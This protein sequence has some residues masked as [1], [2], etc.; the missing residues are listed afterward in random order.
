[1]DALKLA[2]WQ[3]GELERLEELTGELAR[4]L[5]AQPEDEFYLQFVLLESAFAPLGAGRF[6]EAIAR[7]EEALAL[8]RQRGRLIHEP[9]FIDALCW[10]YRSRGDYE[11]ALASGS[12]ASELAHQIGHH[13]WAAW[14]DATLGWA[15]LDARVPAA[16]V[17][18]L[19]RGMQTA[20][21]ASAPAQLVR[22]VALLAWARSMLGE[23]ALA[24]ALATR[25][26]ELLSE[27]TT[28]P[29]GA[30]LFGAHAYLAVARA[31]TGCGYAE[32]AEVLLWPV[33]AAAERTGW[34]EPIACGW[35]VIGQ[36]RAVLD[37]DSAAE[38]ALVRSL[39]VAG[40]AGLPAPAWE[41]HKTLAELLHKVGRQTQA[42]VHAQQA[43][44]ILHELVE[45]L[46]DPALRAGLLA[47]VPAP[48]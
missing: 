17:T 27:V 3:L 35:L 29:D 40:A 38:A 23:H 14:A 9:L 30:W 41:A 42:G 33:V 44:R 13:E 10:A 12:G 48:T 11:R 26:D 21:G 36:A 34:K 7:I 24:A 43:R 31:Y 1:M 20:E 39:E 15:L 16:A 19:E 28:P 25:A 5:R 37:D 32:R 2:A 18:C 4:T 45:P 22:C 6:E 8:L 46:S 47:Q